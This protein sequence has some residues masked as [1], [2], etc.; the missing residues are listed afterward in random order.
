MEDTRRRDGRDYQGE[1]LIG[2]YFFENFWEL[3]EK[4]NFP[5]P[6]IPK[7]SKN[8][9]NPRLENLWWTNRINWIMIWILSDL[10][11]MCHLPLLIIIHIHSHSFRWI[12]RQ[13]WRVLRVVVHSLLLLFRLHSTIL[14][15]NFDLAIRQ[16]GL[17]AEFFSLLLGDVG[18]L[19]EFRFEDRG[20]IALICLTAFLGGGEQLTIVGP[21]CR[22]RITLWPTR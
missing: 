11:P 9:E 16:L 15:P 10:W 17:Q 14:K 4:M 20:L 2:K 18:G 22:V 13:K 19:L 8:H 1:L 7:F 6:K 3:L 21:L 12:R 5:F